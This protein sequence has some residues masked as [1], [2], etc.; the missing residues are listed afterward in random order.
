MNINLP[1]EKFD[2]EKLQKI[3][4]ESP[5]TVGEKDKVIKDIKPSTDYVSKFFYATSEGTY[6]MWDADTQIFDIMDTKKE[7]MYFNKMPESIKKWILKDN[8][9]VF[10]VT[11]SLTDPRV[12]EQTLKINMCKS[13]KHHNV[14]K[15]ADYKKLHSKVNVF[16]TYMKKVLC[17]DNEDHY[18]YLIKWIAN[19][20]QGHKNTS[21]PYLRGP[22]GVGKT[23]LSKFL[24]ENVIGRDLSLNSNG[25]PLMKDFNIILMGKLF[26]NFE[27][28]ESL[29]GK[30]GSCSGKLRTLATETF[31][32]YEGKGT[33]AI[34]A[35]NISNFI[36]C[37]N[38]EA[39]KHSEGRR[40]FILDINTEYKDNTKYWSNLYD[41]CFN[42]KVGEAF[43][44]Y[45]QT[46]DVSN[47]KSQGDMPLTRA[48]L[49]AFAKLLP[50][51]FKFLKEI[52]IFKKQNMKHTAQQLYQLYD[53]YCSAHE[54]KACSKYDFIAKLREIQL[55]FKNKKINGINY[56]VYSHEHLAE[57][58]EKFHWIHEL[59]MD[60]EE[61]NEEESISKNVTYCEP[62]KQNVFQYS[63][64]KKENS[65]LKKQVE[66]LQAQIKE[67]TKPTIKKVVKRIKDIEPVEEKETEEIQEEPTK[68]KA[69]LAT[70]SIVRGQE[71]KLRFFM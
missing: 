47:F 22:E 61:P 69:K 6:F 65:E 15:Y 59:D 26:V 29:D 71:T 5:K 48:K 63:D 66:L 45:M 31:T 30:W 67:L 55:D 40:Y 38:V 62:I 24:Y 53:N 44:S 42:D 54:K 4:D 49:D 36:I 32:D 21:I 19:M 56:Y 57:I 25:S 46:I 58:A 2:L 41:T 12:S 70:S 23:T 3:Y 17:S 52:F 60:N 43:F 20:C 50:N 18:D 37:T 13:W 34:S 27:E 1:T 16:L 51:E 9:K 8:K 68:P 14:K 28:L 11:C 39:V 33:N 35:E 10:K 64:L 7:N